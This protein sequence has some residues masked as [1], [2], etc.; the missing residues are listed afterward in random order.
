MAHART[1]VA[2][3]LI[4]VLASSITLIL[5]IAALALSSF[6]SAKLEEKALQGLQDTNR[7]VT[8]MID[9]YN[10]SLEQSVQRLG[11]LF[12][13]SYTRTFSKH[14]DT[15][16]HGDDAITQNE[17]AIPDRFTK[18]S[19][20]N[21]TVLT[22]RGDDF[23][24]TSTS[25]KTEQ[26]ER[27]S[28][29]L[30]GP[31]HPA[32]PLLLKGEPFTGKARML[33]RDFMTHY[34]PIKG[35]SGE[36]IGAFFVGLDFT[37]GLAALKTKILALKIGQTGYPYAIDHGQNKG[38]ITM[39]PSSEGKSLLGL[40]DAQG[41]KFVDEMLEKKTGIITYW[42]QNP[43]EEKPREKVT[44][45][46]YY[47]PWDWVVA[48]G[49]YLEEFNAEAQ[50]TGRGMLL[51]ALL[52]IPVVVALVW[53]SMRRWIA[54]PL[55]TAA[56][57]AERVAERDFT[58]RIVVSG[59]D[60]IARLMA[61]LATMQT[62]LGNT[63]RQVRDT[64]HSVSADADQLNSAAA[65][66]AADTKTQSEAT[67]RMLVSVEEMSTSI[68]M[69]A[70]H[71]GEVR[72][73]SD[74]SRE[75]AQQSTR[76]IEA[77]VGAMN[78]IA[79]TVRSSAQMVETLGQEVERISSIA[80]TIKEIA[81]QTNLLALNAAIEAARAGEQGRGFAVVADE[82]RK[83]AERTGQ[84]THEISEMIARIQ[85][86]TQDA[87]SN[88]ERGVGEVSE[89]VELATQ[90]STAI[91]RIQQGAAQV[92]TAVS[93]I[94]DTIRE[95]SQASSAV[96]QGLETIAQMTEANNLEAQHTASAA[97]KLHAEAQ[98]LQE[99]VQQFKV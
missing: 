85:E 26:G 12:A 84:S 82:V 51:I 58:Q 3:K 67:H 42:W 77:A 73:A 49:S 79:D 7:M 14:G 21:A 70:Q 88:M 15:L 47:E 31:G 64:A 94:S 68:D 56:G 41:H 22:R 83:L 52:L 2:R 61:S 36:V 19:Q 28:G 46:D 92:S 45:Y 40:G 9:T 66:V 69:I 33:G 65:N 63:I 97:E 35:D 81:D 32:I 10:R 99:S 11:P 78:R 25:V 90:A 59:Q 95:Q 4:L 53:W 48:S 39:H 5:A 38:L 86:R 87:V 30:L 29:T 72:A 98:A 24:R 74:E 71:T 55:E 44:A 89:G 1:S 75:V 91:D 37:E 18:N 27:A 60:E 54:R 57:V 43:S 80:G 96:A 17:T 62:Q 76:T 50:Q 34:L 93:G 8:G 13:A 20:V 23:E 16:Y 6:L